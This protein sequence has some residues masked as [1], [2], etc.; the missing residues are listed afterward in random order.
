M[1]KKPQRFACLRVEE[2][3][4]RVIVRLHRPDVRNAISQEMVDELHEVCA[5]LEAT[6]RLALLVGDGGTFMSGA[7]LAQMQTRGRPDAL[8]GINSALF[9]RVLRLP[10][11]T[12]ALVDGYALGAGAELAYACDFRIGTRRA[13]IGN[14]EVSL[15]IAAAA[16]ATHRLK[17]L[18]GEPLAKEMLLTGRILDA[19]EAVAVRLFGQ[20]VEPDELEHAGHELCDRIANHSSLAV[21][22]T[23]ALYRAPQA[24]HPEIDDIV[25]AVL[26]E[27]PEKYSRIGAFLD[28]RPDR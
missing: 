11:P 28:K 7:D 12:I 5:D 8:R 21:R 1:S 20:L 9:E 18:V 27:T 3:E 26:F 24:A 23:K 17:E 13:R 19:G 2:S 25:Q 22:L 15:G 16:G 14:P 10:M 6:P 4:D